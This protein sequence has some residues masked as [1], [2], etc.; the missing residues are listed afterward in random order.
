[1]VD[2]WV[3]MNNLVLNYGY[4]GIFLI[5][6]IGNLSIVIP[7][8][9]V[10]VIYAFGSILNPILLGLVGGI[11]STIGEFPSYLVGR[12]GRVVLNERQKTRLDRIEKL[13]EKH[14]LLLV[15]LFG[16]LPLP[17]DILLIPL[18]MMKYD[19]RKI[20]LGMFFGKTL[21]CIVVAYAGVYSYEAI[22]NI[23]ESNG[24]LSGVISLILLAAIIISLLKLDWDIILD[25][26]EKRS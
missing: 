10:L 26:L 13:V 25:K 2:I 21:M 11:G 3:L 7:V 14:G 12:G 15:F 18:G 17:D 5:S 16:L 22:R 8:P 4:V 19:W 24:I 1:L 9:F 20:L 6:I 23:Y